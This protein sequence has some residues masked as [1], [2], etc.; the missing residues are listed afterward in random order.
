MSIQSGDN[1]RVVESKLLTFLP[2]SRGRD[3]FPGRQAA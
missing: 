3:A 1:P 2:P